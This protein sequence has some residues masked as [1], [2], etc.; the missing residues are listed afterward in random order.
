MEDE[1]YKYLPSGEVSDRSKKR[2]HIINNLLT[3]L[4]RD[5]IGGYWPS[6]VLHGPLAR[7]PRSIL[8]R[9]RA[10]IPQSSRFVSK[11]PR[12]DVCGHRQVAEIKTRRSMEVLWSTKPESRRAMH[13][14]RLYVFVVVYCKCTTHVTGLYLTKTRWLAIILTHVSFVSRVVC[15]NAR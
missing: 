4:L 7:L 12:V 6:V 8:L 15:K 11:R 10:N 1:Y 9:P 3:S 13:A 2:C 5:R 14:V